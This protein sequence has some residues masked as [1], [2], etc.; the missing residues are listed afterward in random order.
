MEI[1]EFKVRYIGTEPFDKNT[2]TNSLIENDFDRGGM[3]EIEE[4]E[5]TIE[6]CSA[7]NGIGNVDEGA[8]F[9]LDCNECSGTGYTPKE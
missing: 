6:I 5:P 1:K 4:I 3:L 7:C 8:G 9:S 2:L